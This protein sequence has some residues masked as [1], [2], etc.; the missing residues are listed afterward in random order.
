MTRLSTLLVLVAFVGC[1]ADG[2]AQFTA[3]NAAAPAADEKPP[4]NQNNAPADP[5]AGPTRRIIYNGELELIVEDF[6]PIAV[7][8]E[9]VASRYDGYVAKSQLRGR[10][11][12][13]RGGVWTVRVPAPRFAEAMKALEELG[14]VRRAA[15]TSQ[16]VTAEFYDLEARL[17]NKRL[18]EKRLLVHLEQTTGKLDE[19][20][21]VEREL[22]RVRGE[23]EQLQGRLRLL[24]DLAALST[25][26]LTVDEI[27]DYKREP[28]TFAT[29]VARSWSGS[30][31]ALSSACQSLIVGLV[32]FAP[33]AGVMS[34]PGAG[35][36]F[37]IRRR[38]RRRM[39]PPPL[40]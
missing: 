18:E 20:L 22:S 37:L 3:R 4:A 33:W 28:P 36:W 13:P 17:N 6:S 34:A 24:T 1:G 9:E 8:V 15:S 11:G 39:A 25:I 5:Q 40:N 10:T 2:P 26:T 12:Q 29:R 27:R 7:H 19:I 31:A 16:D 14:E 21:T 30:L 38:A 35:T 32:G 23:I